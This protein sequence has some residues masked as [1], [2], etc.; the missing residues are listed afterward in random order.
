MPGFAASP[1]PSRPRGDIR[2]SC[3]AARGRL[4]LPAPAPLLRALPLRLPVPRRLRPSL[5]RHPSIHL[6][7]P[8]CIPGHPGGAGGAGGGARR[9][10]CGGADGEPPAGLPPAPCRRAR[11]RKDVRGL[12][13][14]AE[15]L[16]R[17][18]AGGGR[19]EQP[20][21][22][23]QLHPARPRP[24]AAGGERGDGDG[25]PVLRSPQGGSTERAPAQPLVGLGFCAW[26]AAWLKPARRSE[27]TAV[28]R[29]AVSFYL[30]NGCP[31]LGFFA[32]CRCAIDCP[33]VGSNPRDAVPPDSRGGGQVAK[34]GGF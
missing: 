31:D 32:S 22:A 5:P 17:C 4:R 1:A 24:A 6:S 27:G 23:A 9:R 7:V 8:P 16:G 34:T 29:S 11:P 20:R 30:T 26:L 33:T 12:P 3:S 25:G 18:E 15:P 13:A 28:G 10:G 21:G 14:G 2:R 19:G